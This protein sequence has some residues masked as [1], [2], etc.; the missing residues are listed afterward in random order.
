MPEILAALAEK[1][2]LLEEAT[3]SPTC[4]SVRTIVPPA[5]VTLDARL[6]GRLLPLAIKIYEREVPCAAA[7]VTNRPAVSTTNTKKAIVR[8]IVN[9]P[10]SGTAK[11]DD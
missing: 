1:V 11:Q 8:F 6:A 7:G 2:G 10:L 5:A 4:G 3:T 9:S